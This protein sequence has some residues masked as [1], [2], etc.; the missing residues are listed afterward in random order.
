LALAVLVPGCATPIKESSTKDP[1]HLFARRP[2]HVV[3]QDRERDGSQ[4]LDRA[5]TQAPTEARILATVA[6][7]RERG[8][9]EFHLARCGQNMGEQME[10][11][12]VEDGFLKK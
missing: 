3:I 10:T 8:S 6:N 2:L 12:L 1:G 11:A 5:L 9:R 7:D 4:G